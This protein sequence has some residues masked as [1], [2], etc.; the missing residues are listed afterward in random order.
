MVAWRQKRGSKNS[1]GNKSTD[2]ALDTSSGVSLCAVASTSGTALVS[3]GLA[4]SLSKPTAA[5]ATSMGCT[6]Q[7]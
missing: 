4:W 6:V 2:S 7:P 5:A 3:R 1:S